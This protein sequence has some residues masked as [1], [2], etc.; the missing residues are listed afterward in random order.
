[1]VQQLIELGLTQK[2]RTYSELRLSG[3]SYIQIIEITPDI[4]YNWQIS[5]CLASTAAGFAWNLQSEAARH[6]YLCPRDERELQLIIAHAQ[7]ELIPLTIPSLIEE[8]HGLKE[9]RHR[10]TS[11]VPHQRA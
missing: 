1:M 3:L 5:K 6:Q 4:H 8:A 11:K 9:A 2:K 7:E 10:T